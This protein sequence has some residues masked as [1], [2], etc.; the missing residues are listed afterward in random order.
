[1]FTRKESALLQ[2][3][4]D[5]FMKELK[6]LSSSSFDDLVGSGSYIEKVDDNKYVI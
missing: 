6:P 2:E 4:V 5:Y 3:I 1:M